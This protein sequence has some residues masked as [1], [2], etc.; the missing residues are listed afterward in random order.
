MFRAHFS[1]AEG[2]AAAPVAVQVTILRDTLGILVGH[3]QQP[4]SLTRA[5]A[6]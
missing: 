1:R 5:Q 4:P 3:H 2:E 6:Q